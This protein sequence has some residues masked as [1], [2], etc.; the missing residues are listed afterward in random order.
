LLS[1]SAKPLLRI[2]FSF[3]QQ[4]LNIRTVV[5]ETPIERPKR[6]QQEF[7]SGKKKRRFLSITAW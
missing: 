5:T 7:Y 6:K 3:I 2:G 1:K 4:A